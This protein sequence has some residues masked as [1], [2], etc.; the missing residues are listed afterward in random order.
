MLLRVTI[1]GDFRTNG[2][3]GSEIVDF[4]NVVGVMPFCE[5]DFIMFNVQ[6]RMLQL[7]LKADKRYTQHFEMMRTVHIDNVETIEGEPEI[8]GKN[9]KEMSWEELQILAAYKHL[10]NI[11]AYR[12]TDLRYARE[13][14]YCEY[15]RLILNAGINRE[16]EKFNF[17]K[18]PAIIVD[19][20]SSPA[21]PPKQVSNDEV[22]KGEQVK[23]RIDDQTFTMEELRAIA[24]EKKIKLPPHV[25]YDKAVKLVIG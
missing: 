18:L 6:N 21:E 8:V 24:K 4:E 14:A 16:D 15:S 5:E 23:N 11:P 13:V 3:N 20:E 9:I 1:S 25:S 12:T 19:A 7:W 17:A 10:R 22:L 2:K